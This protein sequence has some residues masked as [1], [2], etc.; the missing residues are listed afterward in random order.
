MKLKVSQLC[1]VNVSDHFC[2]V[3]SDISAVI[4]GLD[5]LKWLQSVDHFTLIVL[6]L[7]SSEIAIFNSSEIFSLHEWIDI[8]HSIQT[9]RKFSIPE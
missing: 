8:I 1:V 3:Y 2:Y 5:G 7:E 6:D 9:C 4:A